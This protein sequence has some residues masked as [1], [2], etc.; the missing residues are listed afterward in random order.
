MKKNKIYI[1]IALLLLGVYAF[2]KMKKKPKSRII[3][4]D[5]TNVNAYS[6]PGTTVYDY[7]LSTPLYTFRS[8][9]KL[10]ILQEDPDL[11]YTKVTFTANNTVKT[12]YIYNNDIIFK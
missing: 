2:A 9:I 12:G 6:I 8:E 3:V 7:N 11:P 5:P 4:S 10:G 1:T